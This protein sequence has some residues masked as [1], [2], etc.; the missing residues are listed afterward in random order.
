MEL[1]K[2]VELIYQYPH[3]SEIYTDDYFLSESVQRLSIVLSI[4]HELGSQGDGKDYCNREAEK[5]GTLRQQVESSL[6]TDDVGYYFKFSTSLL[7]FLS[8]QPM[9]M[10][11]VF[12]PY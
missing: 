8:V 10:L 1:P 12:D 3:S 9:Q 4:R 6:N 11:C 2:S 5:R 7:I